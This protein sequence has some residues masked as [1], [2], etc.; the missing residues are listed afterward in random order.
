[1]TTQTNFNLDLKKIYNCFL[2]SIDHL[3]MFMYNKL[4]GHTQ[5]N[6]SNRK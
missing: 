3:K 1:M 2:I 6:D 5:I 4:K